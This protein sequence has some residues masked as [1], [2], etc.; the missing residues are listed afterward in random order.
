MPSQSLSLCW[1]YLDMHTKWLHISWSQSLLEAIHSKV[2]KNFLSLS[3]NFS[4][5]ATMLL[6]L[7]HNTEHTIFMCFP[8]CFLQCAGLGLLKLIPVTSFFILWWCFSN[9]LV[10]FLATG[11]FWY[12]NHWEGRTIF[13]AFMCHDNS[14]KTDWFPTYLLI[15]FSSTKTG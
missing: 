10:I 6:L 1:G 2:I 12:W 13:K 4:L 9:P 11:I 8:C 15:V 5:G 14:R 7:W 3:T